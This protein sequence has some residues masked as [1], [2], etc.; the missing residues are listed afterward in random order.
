MKKIKKIL[1]LFMSAVM[2]LSLASCGSAD[3]T[4]E[5]YPDEKIKIG[6][7]TF[8]T[9]GDQFIAVQQYLDK[10]SEKLNIEIIYSESINNAEQ[11][12]S[13]IESVA[14]AGGKGHYRLLQYFQSTGRTIMCR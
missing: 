9:A 1:M 12:L 5:K 7:I 8:D 4:V 14:A 10:L 6:F 13:F 3:S 11:E 2:L